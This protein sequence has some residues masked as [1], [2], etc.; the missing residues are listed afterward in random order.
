M[1]RLHHGLKAG[2]RVYQLRC[3]PNS[4]ARF[5]NAAFKD[6]T[7]SLFTS[8]LFYVTSLALVDHRRIA[9]D[10]TASLSK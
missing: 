5:P 9:G 2:C 4:V 10:L 6:I 1:T 3:D 7:H 8:Q